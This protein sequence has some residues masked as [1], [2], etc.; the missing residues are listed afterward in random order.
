MLC[1]RG[2]A[3]SFSGNSKAEK[4]VWTLS[5]EYLLLFIFRETISVDKI[6]L[7]KYETLL[8]VLTPSSST[9]TPLPM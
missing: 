9:V 8:A 4:V 7:R 5:N 2:K 3:G 6:L 1:F